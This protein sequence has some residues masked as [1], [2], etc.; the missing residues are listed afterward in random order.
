MAATVYLS[1]GSNLGNRFLNLARAIEKLDRQD[2]VKV[3]SRSSCYETDPV[4]H[5]EQPDFINMA[6][7]IESLMPPDRLLNKIKEIEKSLGRAE[8]FRWGPRIID[9]DILLYENEVISTPDLEIPHPMMHERAFVL[10][11]LSEIAA[12]ARHP[13]S[14][15]NVKEMIEGMPC[16]KGIRKVDTKL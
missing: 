7:K 10:L 2:G 12:D 1:L 13:A 15:K 8:T 16:I 14:G 9:I 6:V 4:G 3:L 11:P 5:E